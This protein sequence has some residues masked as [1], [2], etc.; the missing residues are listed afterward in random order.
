MKFLLSDSATANN[1]PIL[2]NQEN[3]I[4]RDNSYKLRK[5]FPGFHVLIN[6]ALKN[7]LNSG[8]PRNGMFIAFPDSIKNNVEDVSP[9]YWR[10]QAAKISFNT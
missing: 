5:A 1:I 3:F 6:P 2:Y 9:G 8:R 7:Q 10:V 4:L